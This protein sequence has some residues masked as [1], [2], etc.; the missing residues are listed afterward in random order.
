MTAKPTRLLTREQLRDRNLDRPIDAAVGEIGKQ[1]G[2]LLQLE[3]TGQ[4]S[5]RHCQRQ[6]LPLPPKFR[7][8]RLGNARRRAL[9]KA[10]PAPSA[11]KVSTM[12]GRAEMASRRNGACR[13]RAQSPLRAPVT[14]DRFTD[15]ALPE[16]DERGNFQRTRSL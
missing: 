9:R 3:L 6:C 1:T 16:T 7:P 15:E 14:A 13:W 11:T 8:G 12:S 10:A 2:D 4:V 5:E